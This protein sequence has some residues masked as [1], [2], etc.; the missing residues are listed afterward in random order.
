MLRLEQEKKL[1]WKATIDYQQAQSAATFDE[2]GVLSSLGPHGR[3]GFLVCER[4]A[5]PTPGRDMVE[6]SWRSRAARIALRFTPPRR[7]C[8]NLIANREGAVEWSSRAR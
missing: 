8:S 7:S 1:Y 2:S 5:S 4:P 6:T 3:V